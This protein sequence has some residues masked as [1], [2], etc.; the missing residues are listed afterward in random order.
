M[1]RRK[2]KRVKKR[3]YVQS[4]SKTG[5]TIDISSNGLQVAVMSKP[6]KKGIDLQVKV[7]DTMY[8]LHGTIRWFAR[9]CGTGDPHHLGIHIKQI[10]PAYKMALLR[11]YPDLLEEEETLIDSSDEDTK[12]VM[13][14]QSP[15]PAKRKKPVTR[16]VGFK[17]RTTTK[18]VATGETR[19]AGTTKPP[20]RVKSAAAI[21]DIK[22]RRK[23][24]RFKNV[25]SLSGVLTGKDKKLVVADFST[26]GIKFI[27]EY[28]LYVGDTY[29]VDL[30][31]GKETH[32]F[33]IQT[34][35]AEVLINTGEYRKMF[36]KPTVYAIGAKFVGLDK[37]RKMFIV[38][39]LEEI[40]RL[41]PG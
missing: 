36:S 24:R 16:M 40:T 17:P 23:N 37:E 27:S 31:M 10:P 35:R 26:D 18:V 39:W 7:D 20:T 11:L 1:E 22:N 29:T 3:L 6:I 32:R 30:L 2:F 9:G 13:I 8:D 38:R 5:I 19:P 28:A 34:V 25:I 33:D 41:R 14:M 21:R 12:K 4:N 15:E